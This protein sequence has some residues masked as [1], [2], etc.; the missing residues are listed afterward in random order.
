MQNHELAQQ[1][2]FEIR[3]VVNEMKA[4]ACDHFSIP[5][6]YARLSAQP[7]AMD[8]LIKYLEHVI[9]IAMWCG[10]C[11]SRCMPLWTRTYVR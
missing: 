4:M 6:R 7:Y 3:L 8:W 11:W 10:Y 1:N 2:L 9:A 5:I